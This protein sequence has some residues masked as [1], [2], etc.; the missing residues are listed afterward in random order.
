MAL[1]QIPQEGLW[2][3]HFSAQEPATERTEDLTSSN[4]GDTSPAPNKQDFSLVQEIPLQKHRQHR[5]N[6]RRS[7]ANK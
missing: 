6:E 3:A 5:P 2:A 1:S 4:T 7:K